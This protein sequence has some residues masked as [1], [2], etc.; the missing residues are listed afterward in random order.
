[1]TASSSTAAPLATASPAVDVLGKQL[2]SERHQEYISPKKAA[3]H[4]G[5][6]PVWR[7]D[8]LAVISDADPIW[9]LARNQHEDEGWVPRQAVKGYDGGEHGNVGYVVVTAEHM[10]NVGLPPR[11]P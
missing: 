11:T 7:G 2:L 6:L 4:I 9:L 3:H 8:V 1:M 5:V 10:P